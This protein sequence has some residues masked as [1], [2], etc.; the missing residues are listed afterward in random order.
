M[1]TN[2]CP[3]RLFHGLLEFGILFFSLFRVAANVHLFDLWLS[4]AFLT[5]TSDSSSTA[6]TVGFNPRRSCIL[7]SG[8][9][10]RLHRIH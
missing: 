5:L 9:H 10:T 1:A 3:D 2:H 6:I 7:I 4:L 8:Y